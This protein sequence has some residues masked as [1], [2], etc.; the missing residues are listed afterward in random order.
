MLFRSQIGPVVDSWDPS[1]LQD[2]TES[3]FA[4]RDTFGYDISESV[5]AAN[6]MMDQF[7]IDGEYAFNLIA[8]GAQNGLDFSGELIDSINEYS[9]QFEKMGMSA[10]DMFHIF[11]AGADS[12]AFNLDKIGD[13]VKENAIRV[14]DCSDTTADAYKKLGLDVDE[15]SKKFAAGGDDARSAFEQVMTGLIALQDPLEQNT[16][17]TELFG[18]MWEDLGPDV[19]GALADIEEGAYATGEE[20]NNIKDIKYDDLGSM[21]EG[22]KR[23]V[24]MLMEPLG[25]ELVPILMELMDEIFPALQDVLT[26]LIE[27]A[28]MILEPLL[29]LIG[30]CLTPILAIVGQLLEP[31]GELL[32]TCL[33][34]LL[35]LVNEILEPL[36]SLLTDCLN[37][38][39]E[40]I[41][42]GRAHV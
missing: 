35:G 18:T 2:F 17:G 36:G 12:G 30:D 8:A 4:L 3:A 33:E 42:I 23:N 14:I 22:L 24:E 41:K 29:S 38:L 19:V 5:R 25:Q 15:M 20:L 1:A 40:V 32:G 10:D 16:I 7:G 27:I 13:A 21:F 31:M 6:T 37:P 28:G 9:V 39:L 11:Q 26:P 34:P